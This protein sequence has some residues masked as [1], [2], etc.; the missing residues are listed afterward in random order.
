MNKLKGIVLMA[1]SQ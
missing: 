1:C